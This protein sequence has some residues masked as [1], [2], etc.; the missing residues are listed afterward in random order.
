VFL[1]FACYVFTHID[2]RVGQVNMKALQA[3]G[4][5]MDA[6]LRYYV[7]QVRVYTYLHVHST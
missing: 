4:V 3:G 2:E 6:M 5:N 1:L 7:F